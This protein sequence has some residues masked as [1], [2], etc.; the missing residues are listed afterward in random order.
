MEKHTGTAARAGNSEKEINHNDRPNK[1]QQHSCP[2]FDER[3]NH[4]TL[5]RKMN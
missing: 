1:Q 5:R 2:E 3:V 4:K